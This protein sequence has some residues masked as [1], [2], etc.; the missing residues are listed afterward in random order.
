[1]VT[2]PMGDV[3]H[4]VSSAT[5]RRAQGG[6]SDEG[7]FSLLH[8][9]PVVLF[10]PQWEIEKPAS[11]LWSVLDGV[12]DRVAHLVV[13]PSWFIHERR[14]IELAALCHE[15][16]RRF[17]HVVV[18]AS[19][20]TLGEAAVL[21]RHDVAAFQCGVSAFIRDDFFTLNPV[22]RR[23]FDAIY[24]AQW[25]DYKRH[26]LAGSVRSLA[27]IAARAPVPE[28]HSV[29]YSL[30]ARIAVRHA[31]WLSSPLGLTK[32]RWLRQEEV[33]LAYGQARVGL[34]LS[35]VEGVMFASVQYLLAGLPVVT[36]RN[37]GG[38]DEF[39]SAPFVRWVDDDPRAVADAVDELVMLDL[40]PQAI[41][42]ATLTKIRQHRSRMQGWIQG[43]I[44]AEGGQPGRWRGEWP[45]GLPNKLR[46]PKVRAVDVLAEINAIDRRR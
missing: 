36:T 21:Q 5:P 45:A 40:D 14:G 33:N 7:W 43:V 26:H 4:S 17:S 30:R 19:C 32:K 11:A 12:S 15:L 20:A 1:M 23:R 28:L 16:Q 3:R 44:L 41:R 2:I 38:R 29:R 34:C 31:T 24:D 10:A 39:F 25:A 6:H 8:R 42:D 27:L 22:R 37:L 9:D 35:R 18:T 13:G 46:E